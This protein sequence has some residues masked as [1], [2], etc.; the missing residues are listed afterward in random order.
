M[1]E[2]CRGFVLKTVPYGDTGL[3]VKALTDTRG[4]A[5]F[6]VQGAKR[7]GKHSKAGLFGPMT[8]ISLTY[9]RKENRDLFTARQVS[10]HQ[11]YPTLHTHIQ[12]PAV[13]VYMAESLYRA[14]GEHHH[15]DELYHFAQAQMQ[16][17]DDTE[18]LAHFPQQFL[19]GLIEMFGLSPHGRYSPQTPDFL[20]NESTFMP[21]FSGEPMFAVR[22]EAAQYI[23]DLFTPGSPEN[24]YT[25]EARRETRR[26]LEDYLK[27][28][29]D[30]RFNLLSG[31]V[32]ETVFDE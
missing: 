7:K 5:S 4:A 25:R 12:K 17:L 23:S 19:A 30:G 22:G 31:E 20:L 26:R 2:T 8:H 21:A 29:L 16:K 11:M 24:T 6:M 3:V 1:E 18:R 9:V 15:E 32:L 27:L 13:T 28:H 10:V 14:T